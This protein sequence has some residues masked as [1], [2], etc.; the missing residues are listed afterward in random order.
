MSVHRRG[1]ERELPSHELLGAVGIWLLRKKQMAGACTG[2]NPTNLGIIMKVI[3]RSQDLVTEDE[4][5]GPWVRMRKQD[6]KVAVYP[7][8]SAFLDLLDFNPH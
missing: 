1:S 2:S 4:R 8:L 5:M 6:C 7:G 3:I